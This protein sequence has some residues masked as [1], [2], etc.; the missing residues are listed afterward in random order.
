MDEVVRGTDVY[1]LKEMMR[2]TKIDTTMKYYHIQN[3]TVKGA[4]K[5]KPTYE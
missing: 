1:T 2:H 4:F 3:E 5:S